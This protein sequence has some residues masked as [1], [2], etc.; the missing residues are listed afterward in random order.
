VS[1]VPHLERTTFYGQKGFQ[2]LSPMA[3]KHAVALGGQGLYLWKLF[4]PQLRGAA[5][6][7]PCPARS[8]VSI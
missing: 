7:I 6:S 4:V 8:P 3:L 1:I 5:E 2:R